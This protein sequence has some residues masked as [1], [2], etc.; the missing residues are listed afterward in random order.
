MLPLELA[1]LG[2]NLRDWYAERAATTYKQDS[3]QLGMLIFMV[4]RGGAINAELDWE[5]NRAYRPTKAFLETATPEEVQAEEWRLA[6]VYQKKVT[7]YW[8]S[9]G[10]YNPE[11]TG[12]DPDM[13]RLILGL[14]NPDLAKRLDMSMVLSDPYLAP[15]VA[16][17]NKQLRCCDAGLSAGA[18]AGGGHLCRCL[19]SDQQQRQSQEPP[20][21]GAAHAEPAVAAA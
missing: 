1:R 10:A 21:P 14:T 12:V 11:L 9:V 13:V 7:D 15:Y 18:A 6:E 5:N 20:G 3:K 19:W 16:S 8:L 2:S 4:L 17:V